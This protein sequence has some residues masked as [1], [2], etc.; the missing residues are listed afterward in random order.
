MWPR[1][2]AREDVVDHVSWAKGGIHTTDTFIVCMIIQSSMYELER[3][4]E[5]VPFEVLDQLGDSVGIG[6]CL[7]D[8]GGCISEPWIQP[9]AVEAIL[10]HF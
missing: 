5:S 3:L 9:S 10:K 6:S 8:H 4:V 1:I 7:E 2:S